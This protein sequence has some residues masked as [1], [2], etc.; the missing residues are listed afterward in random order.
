[1]LGDDFDQY[2]IA[3]TGRFN[4]GIDVERRLGPRES[5]GRDIDFALPN[6]ARQVR[7]DRRGVALQDFSAFQQIEAGQSSNRLDRNRESP[8]AGRE[9]S[10]LLERRTDSWPHSIDEREKSLRKKIERRRP[11]V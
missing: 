4:R 10:V 6:R 11:G 3:G 5:F 7:D 2:G 1:M 8:S 9:E